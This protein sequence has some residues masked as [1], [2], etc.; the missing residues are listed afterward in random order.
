MVEQ[1]S[2]KEQPAPSAGRKPEWAWVALSTYVLLH[3]ACLGVFWTGLT[4]V[5]FQCLLVGF[6]VRMWG[7]TVGYHRYFAHRAFE[8]SRVMQFALA[9]LGTLC[10]QG[11]VLWWAETHRRH[12]RHAD[13]PEDLHSPHYQGFFYSHYGW[14]LDKRHRGVRLE[15]IKD[16]AR[17]PELVWLDRWHVLPFAAMS[18]AVTAAFGVGGLLWGVFIP[19]VLMWEITH[20]VQSFSHSWAGYRRFDSADQSRNHWVLGVLALGEFHNNHHTHP[21]AARQGQVWW[22]LDVGYWGLRLLSA[23]GLVWELRQ[24]SARAGEGKS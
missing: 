19:T 20:W 23:L 21:S 7:L 12:H 15:R 9:L 11:G 6:L 24:P 14:F 5:T 13:T 8:T 17:Y 18:L 3:V 10:L 1:E 2:M 22:E 4:W 16:L